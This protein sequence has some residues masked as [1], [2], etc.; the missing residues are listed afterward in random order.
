MNK[1]DEQQ[2]QE[3]QEEEEHNENGEPSHQEN[4]PL[5]S[6]TTTL[7][8]DDDL[9]FSAL[10]KDQFFIFMVMRGVR[11]LTGRKRCDVEVNGFAIMGGAVE[12]LA[13][14]TVS[15]LVHLYW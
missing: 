8:V 12:H 14:F 1:I 9:Q 5:S 3:L 11:H 6:S 15:L 4:L 10:N 13:R 7:V 2:E